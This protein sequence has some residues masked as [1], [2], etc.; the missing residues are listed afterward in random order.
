MSRQTPE[1]EKTPLS[2]LL[3]GIAG[4]I[5]L[6]VGM[7]VFA[8]T[9]IDIFGVVEPIDGLP[10][11]VI[12]EMVPITDDPYLIPVEQG[13]GVGKGFWQVFFTAPTGERNRALWVNGI[14]TVLAQAIDSAQRTLDIAAFEFNN[15]AMTDALSR[16]VA[17]GVRVRMVTDDEH[18]LED[19]DTTLLDLQLLNVPIVDDDRSALMHNKFIIVDGIT[20]WTGSMNYTM[21]GVYRNNNHILQ[22]RSR[23]AVQVYQAEFDEM[24]IAREFGPRSSD[25]NTGN[26]TVDGV[27]MA[28]IFAP[29]NDVIDT[30]LAEVAKA[31]EHIFFMAFSFTRDDLG[32]AMVDAYRRGVRVSGIFETVGSSTEF[33]EMKRLFCAGLDVS[34]DG[35]AGILHHKVIII[36]AQTVISG[37]FNFSDNAVRNNDEN[38]VILRDRDLAAQFLAEYSRLRFEAKSPEIDCDA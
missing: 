31:R 32:L 28:I 5:V 35:N 24:F 4:A 34:R 37:S 38:L 6:F 17:R 8:L 29:E 23:R 36:D 16:A 10:T 26:F 1:K 15:E 25:A 13:F 18:G 14:D 11:V 20:V 2:R 3:T 33:S 30:I 21:N 7:V 22:L 12:T 9:G 27:P 19:D